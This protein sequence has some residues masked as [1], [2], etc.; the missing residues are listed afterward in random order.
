MLRS[1]W[2][3]ERGITGLETAIILIAFV[4]VATVFAFVVLTTG[5][6]SAERGK[7]TVFAGLQ[8][9]RGTMEVRGGVLVRATPPNVDSIE[10][11]V[12]TTAGGDPIPLD[13]AATSLRT[14][15]AYRD[16]DMADNDVPYTVTVILGDTDSLLEPGELFTVT[17]NIAD[18]TPAPTITANSRWTLELQT[19]VGAVV[20]LTRSMPGELDSIMQLH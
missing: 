11:T 15:I 13:P 7:E 6:F 19:P 12:G 17:V 20:D 4:V 16:A 18:I 5:I 10:F 9:A 3:D 2:R 14:V 8:K 1:F